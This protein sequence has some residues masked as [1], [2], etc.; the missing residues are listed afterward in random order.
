MVFILCIGQLIKASR[1]LLGIR[2]GRL[3]RTCG[4]SQV[5]LSRIENGHKAPSPEL[6]IRLMEG[7]TR[8]G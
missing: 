5:Q 7:L 2:Q 3:A 8:D 6:L 1:A 4:I